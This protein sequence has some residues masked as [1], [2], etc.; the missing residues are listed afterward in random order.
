MINMFWAIV[1][2]LALFA[3]SMVILR[4]GV[5]D[6]SGLQAYVAVTISF[7]AIRDRKI[8]SLLGESLVMLYATQLTQE[9][10]S[11]FL[12]GA[13]GVWYTYT[14]IVKRIKALGKSR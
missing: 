10:V 12:A 4:Y 14:A 5:W 1:V 2:E 6:V 9:P 3:I 11:Y 13:V 8:P 7:W